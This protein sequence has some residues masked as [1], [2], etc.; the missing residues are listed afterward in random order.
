MDDS[1]SRAEPSGVGSRWK[2]VGWLSAR[3]NDD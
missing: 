1:P 3:M 2:Q